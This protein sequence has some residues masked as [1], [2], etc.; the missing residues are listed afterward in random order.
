MQCQQRCLWA[1]GSSSPGPK[2]PFVAH[3][4][5]CPCGTFTGEAP[6]DFDLTTWPVHSNPEFE[7][8]G[9]SDVLGLVECWHDFL[10]KELMWTNPSDGVLGEW[11]E[12][13]EWIARSG[14]H[15]VAL[16]KR[17]SMVVWR[18]VIRQKERFPKMHVILRAALS[19]TIGSVECERLFSTMNRINRADRRRL[20]LDTIEREVV[21]MRDSLPWEQYDFTSALAHY[22]AK[23]TTNSFVHRD[24]SRKRR[25]VSPTDHI[26]VSSSKDSSSDYGVQSSDQGR[27][28][29]IQRYFND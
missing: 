12:V 18:D 29:D 14:V 20:N 26:S 22:A 28:C 13:K 9:D 27:P 21:V 2:G 1:R 11:G 6:H 7:E 24:K 10:K 8:V 16:E 3:V 5:P 25:A 17:D 4:I 15:K 19:L 23:R